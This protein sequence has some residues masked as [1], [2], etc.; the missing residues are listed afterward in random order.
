[1]DSFE[2]LKRAIIAQVHAQVPVQ[3]VWAHCQSTNPEQGTMVAVRD[4]LEYHDVLLGLGPHLVV[5]ATGSKVLLGLVENQ[6]SATF[7]IHAESIHELRLNGKAHGGLVLADALAARLNLLEQDLN[8]LKAALST[9]TPTAPPT[10]ADIATLKAALIGFST[11][12]LMP[13][14]SIQLQNSKVYHG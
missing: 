11:T 7:M 12:P 13:T 3:T 6:R 14:S 9:W 2:R 10:P 5:P 1:M 8:N 4:G